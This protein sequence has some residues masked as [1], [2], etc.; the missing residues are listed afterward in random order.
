MTNSA[1]S[2]VCSMIWHFCHCRRYAT[3]WLSCVLS[4]QRTPEDLLDYFDQVRTSLVVSEIP[5]IN[6]SIQRRTMPAR[7]PPELWNVHAVTLN[8]APT[9]SL[10]DGTTVCGTLSHHYLCVVLS[11]WSLSIG[12]QT[13]ELPSSP[14]GVN[15]T[16]K[17]HV[18]WRISFVLWVMACALC[19]ND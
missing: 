4:L 2:A 17:E 3:E 19:A 5:V 7:F 13:P 12:R 16:C 11:N 9:T 6:R 10:K 15:S 1:C 14:T 18:L 8:I